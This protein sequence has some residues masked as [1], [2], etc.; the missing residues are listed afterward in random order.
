MSTPSDQSGSGALNAAVALLGVV[1]ALY[2]LRTAPIAA[3][4]ALGGFIGTVALLHR[5]LWK[6]RPDWRVLPIPLLV[7]A[8][9][10]SAAQSIK[11]AVRSDEITVSM[12]NV[13]DHERV[14]VDGRKI[15]EADFLESSLSGAALSAED[16]PDRDRRG[17]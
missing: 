6:V 17:Q 2:G 3:A 14:Y 16:L 13:D 8:A 1:A 9:L 7:A 5:R 10:F 12:F 15:G 4:V 11:N